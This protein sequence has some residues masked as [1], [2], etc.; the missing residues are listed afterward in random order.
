M[1]QN[2]NFA[3]P[4]LFMN[5]NKQNR[6][7]V[8]K[9]YEILQKNVVKFIYSNNNIQKI[10]FTLWIIYGKICLINRVC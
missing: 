9:K 10:V 3:A 4:F 7:N 8:V 6:K 1:Q 5:N 2:E